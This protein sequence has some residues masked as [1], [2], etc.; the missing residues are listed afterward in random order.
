MGEI[1]IREGFDNMDFNAVTQMLSRAKWSEGI[2]EAEVRQGAR[3]SALVVGAFEDGRQVGYARVISDRTRFAY[4]SDVYVDDSCRGRGVASKMVRD[5]L[6]NET[7]KDVYQW[8][9]KSAA[10]ELYTKIG[11]RPVAKPEAWMEIRKPRPKR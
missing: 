4:I 8:C 11:F 3:F 7:L 9:L 6:A 5:L 2:S 10:D 1:E